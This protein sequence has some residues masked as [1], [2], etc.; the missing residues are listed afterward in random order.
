MVHVATVVDNGNGNT[1]TL[2]LL[3]GLDH[4]GVLINGL[5]VEVDLAQMPLLRKKLPVI[6][7]LNQ[8]RMSQIHQ[9]ILDQRFGQRKYFLTG[10]FL[11]G[12][13]KPVTQIFNFLVNTQTQTLHDFLACLGFCIIIELHEKIFCIEDGPFGFRLHQYPPGKAGIRLLDQTGQ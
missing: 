12:Q 6:P 9:G 7:L 10:S 4:M 5:A 1:L 8:F 13:E 2:A 3:P 11:G